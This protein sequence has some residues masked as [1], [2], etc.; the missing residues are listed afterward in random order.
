ML[1]NGKYKGLKLKN[2]KIQHTIRFIN[3]AKV[4]EK[5]VRGEI[6]NKKSI[7]FQE[8]QHNNL[9]LGVWNGEKANH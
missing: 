3:I 1:E 2:E 5:K 9:I 7:W 8:K 4:S 6:T